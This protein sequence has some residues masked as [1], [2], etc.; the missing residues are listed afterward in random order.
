MVVLIE[1]EKSKLVKKKVKKSCEEFIKRCMKD[2]E[3]NLNHEPKIFVHGRECRQRRDVGFFSNDSIGYHY[4]GQLAESIPL[5][6]N[7]KRLLKKINEHFGTNFNGILI[8]R[9]N[10]GKKVIGAHS[11]DE[12][13][14]DKGGVVSISYG[15]TRKFR[16]RDKKTKKIVKNI[17]M[18]SLDIIHM[19]GDFQKEFTHE[20]P[21]ESKVKEC[22][23]SFTFRNH[24]K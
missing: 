5:T 21:V 9:Y 1:T 6:K 19:K 20:I 15:A 16:I 14:L 11:D 2:I 17:F 22:R 18:E 3:D 10:D 8:N 13:Y 4:S 12:K 7:L 23:Y 24:S